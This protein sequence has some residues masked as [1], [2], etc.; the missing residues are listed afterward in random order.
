MSAAS[1]LGPASVF[2]THTHVSGFLVGEIGSAK[3]S[4]GYTAATGPKTWSFVPKH[5]LL[6]IVRHLGDFDRMTAY[7]KNMQP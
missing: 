2:V 1:S 5:F 3:R 6:D 4:A 7:L